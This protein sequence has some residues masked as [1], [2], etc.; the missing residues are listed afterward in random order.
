[1]TRLILVPVPPL[2][3]PPWPDRIRHTWDARANL[4]AEL[5][6]RAGV[7][8]NFGQLVAEARELLLAG[9]HVA[10]DRR[11]T[12]RRFG[13]AVI[14]AWLDDASLARS[15]VSPEA[16]RSLSAG[17]APSRLTTIATATLFFTHFDRLEM[18]HR[19]LF[20]AVRDLVRRAVAAQPSRHANDIIE[21]IRGHDALLLE[22][23]GPIHLAQRLLAT[24]EDV[25]SWFRA[26]HLTAHA[27]SRLGRIARDAYYLTLIESLDAE[28][29]DHDFLEVVTSDVL[30]RQRTESTDE[31]RLYFGHQVLTALT[32]KTTRHPSPGW[33][34]AALDIGG[35]PRTRQTPEWKTWWSRVPPE[36]LA[37]AVNWMRGLE[38]RAFLDGVESYATDK[39]DEAMLR[40]LARRKK[41]L[42]GL[43]EQD[44][45]NDVRLILGDSI[46]KDMRRRTKSSLPDAALLQDASKTDTAVVYV[47]CGDFWLVE[48]S[49]SF[50]LQVYTGGAVDKLANRHVTTFSAVELR[51]SIPRNHQSYGTNSQLIVAHRGF[52]WLVKVLDFLVYHGITVDERGLMT[53]N[54][55]AELRR[56][57]ANEGHWTWA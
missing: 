6:A 50:K 54:D 37:L 40:M 23:G 34:K 32:S 24:G 57:R 18:W 13:R 38:L 10:L 49:H 28:N 51:E 33:L 8:R 56:R 12:E 42:L 16:I 36:N 43:Y 3:L 41:L 19:G 14:A 7:G 35:D 26:N 53:A 2:Q 47:D 48:G 25:T 22:L 31:D 46:R 55:Y 15:T 30:A 9:D 20:D 17:A 11:L 5:S 45:I 1:M 29:G 44:R 4:A 39:E 21:T 27:D 52:E